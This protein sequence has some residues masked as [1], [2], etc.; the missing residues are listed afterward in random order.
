MTMELTED[1]VLEAVVGLPLDRMKG[2]GEGPR[3]SSDL[4]VATADFF[5]EVAF[6]LQDA[7]H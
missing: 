4:V 3:H 5:V 7:I 1:W 2:D 6:S